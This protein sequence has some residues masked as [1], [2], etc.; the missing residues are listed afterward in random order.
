MRLVASLVAAAA[1]AGCA[2]E[3]E[4]GVDDGKA[5]GLAWETRVVTKVT[6]AVVI[7]AVTYRSSGLRVVGQVCRP[8]APGRHR[9]YIYAHGGFAGIADGLG[10][11]W[12]GGACEALAAEGWVV[13]VPAYRGEDGSEGTIEICLGEVDD[14]LEMSRIAL[15]QSYSDP[16]RVAIVGA[17][18]GGCITLRALQRGL[19]AQVAVDMFGPTDW[20]SVYRFWEAQGDASIALFHTVIGGTPDELP[21][22]YAQRSPM[23][24]AGL[25]RFEGSLLVAHGVADELVPQWNSCALAAVEGNFASYH[26]D[27]FQRI[28]PTAPLGCTAFGQTWEAQPVAPTWPGT[29]FLA[30][31]D[32]AGHGATVPIGDALQATAAT[33]LAV[34][35][36]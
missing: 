26:V 24:F 9:V 14:L 22:A 20:A 17:S 16:D 13:V 3:T 12:N 33:F 25:D 34:K 5:D 35:G 21:D 27:V 29:R 2:I 7:E 11:Q 28:V 32:G 31:F 4:T 19:R 30:M 18:H 6:P 36:P 15:A 8:N 10:M 1:V 23:T